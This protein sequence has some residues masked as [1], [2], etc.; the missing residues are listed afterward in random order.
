MRPLLA[1]IAALLLFSPAFAFAQDYN[2]VKNERSESFEFPYT[3]SN[4]DDDNPLVYTFDEPKGPS[5][6]IF[7]RNN[8]SYVAGEDARTVIRIQEPAPSEKYIEI[9]TYG[10]ESKRFWVAVNTV[11]AG[12]A[13]MYDNRVG[14][15]T[16]QGPI[17]VTHG[18][19]AGLSVTNGNR[20]VL[21]RLDLEGFM[22]GSI[23]VYGN[24]G[25]KTTANAYAGVIGFEILFGS[26]SE[27]P[28]YFV[29]AAVTAGVGG[30]IAVLLI[31]KK[32]K[33]D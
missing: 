26:F 29:P 28:V 15:W 5:W 9:V 8:V 20:I 3:A 19:N 12:Y 13:R 6:I 22:V 16:T 21:D 14:G 23:A 2:A 10:G 11:E 30:V 7:I 31:F 27:S 1:A 18:E 33:S 32:R 25:E 4:L 24:D 17:T